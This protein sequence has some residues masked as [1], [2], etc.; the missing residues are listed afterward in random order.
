MACFQCVAPC[1]NLN[2]PG[3]DIR[4]QIN[5][6]LTFLNGQ[7]YTSAIYQNGLGCSNWIIFINVFIADECGNRPYITAFEAANSTS[8]ITNL[9]NGNFIGVF[10]CPF[11]MCVCTDPTNGTLD[12]F[13]GNSSVQILLFPVNTTVKWLSGWACLSVN[14]RYSVWLWIR[15]YQ[16]QRTH[17]H[18]RQIFRICRH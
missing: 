17:G 15:W 6:Q 1:A 12:C 10:T 9:K 11:A 8:V 5:P 18:H 4:K 3:T 16:H 7:P 2:Y 13:R 14:L